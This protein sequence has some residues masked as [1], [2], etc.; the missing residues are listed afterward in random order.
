MILEK[1]LHENVIGSPTYVIR[2]KALENL[3]Y[4]FNDKF[5]IIG[6]YDIYTRLAVNWKFN[7]VQ[8]PVAYVRIHGKNESLLNRNKEI[9]EM[10][11]WYNEI[12]NNT[13][14]SSFNSLNKVPLLISYLETMEVILKEKFTKAFLLVVKYPLSLNKVKLLIA[15]L[16]P[17]FVLKKIKNY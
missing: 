11:S 8:T 12:K 17:K 5:H 10:K 9:N 13:A 7:C 3:K 4:N 14:F 1:L 6:D 15:L 16:L 2:R